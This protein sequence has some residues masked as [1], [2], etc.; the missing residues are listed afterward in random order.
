MVMIGSLENFSAYIPMAKSFQSGYKM[1]Y[2]SI[3]RGRRPRRPG[4][5]SI[6]NQQDYVNVIGHNYI[7]INCNTPDT[8]SGQNVAL[9]N[10]PRF[11]QLGLRG[12]EGAAPYDLT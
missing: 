6:V 4:C 8:V 10:L 2:D 9:Y 3:C 7:F 1:W 5:R 12:V 11:R